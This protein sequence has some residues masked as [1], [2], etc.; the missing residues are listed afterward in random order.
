MDKMDGQERSERPTSSLLSL[1]PIS[2]TVPSGYVAPLNSAHLAVAASPIWLSE[3][4]LLELARR[5]ARE[6]C[7]ELDR[8]R[9]LVVREVITTMGDQLILGYL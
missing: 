1:A 4:E 8:G 3:L 2:T 5:R 7:P 9:A 6:R